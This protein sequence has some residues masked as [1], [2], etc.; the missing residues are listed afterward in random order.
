MCFAMQAL[1]RWPS[2][3]FQESK[4][5]MEY[6]LTSEQTTGNKISSILGR[7]PIYIIIQKD[8]LWSAIEDTS[9]CH[10][11]LTYINWDLL[12]PF[13]WAFLL[14]QKLGRLGFLERPSGL[15][16]TGLRKLKN[17]AISANCLCVKN[18]EFQLYGLDI[19]LNITG[20]GN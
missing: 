4:G 8:A 14:F 13:S 2:A 20:M 18:R 7:V 17:A 3:E 6:F 15:S 1:A 16:G 10:N 19:T 11:G 12:L 5:K 9:H